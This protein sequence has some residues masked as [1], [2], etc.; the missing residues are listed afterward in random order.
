MT[1]YYFVLYF[2]LYGFLGWCTE[3]IYAAFKEKKFVNRG[4]LNGPLCP[5]YGVGVVV[6]VYF[7]DMFRSNLVLLYV[8]SVILV[9]TL[10]WVTGFIMEKLFRHKW[11]DYS[12]IPL[13]LNGYVC[14]PFSLIWG[15]GCVLIVDFI[16]PAV[17]SLMVHLPFK[18]GVVLMVLMGFGLIADIYVTVVGIAKIN[19]RLDKME[20]VAAELRELAENLGESLYKG[21]LDA[22]AKKEEVKQKF[23][24]SESVAKRIQELKKNYND[25]AAKRTYVSGRLMRAFP[26]MNSKK[27][28]EAWEDLRKRFKSS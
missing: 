17:H 26:K 23:D 6:V 4:F 13:N 20:K 15:V 18:L 5:I 25:L 2:F 21:V 14:L 1:V 19:Q 16:H 10:E 9:T 22:L 7:L 8:T 24:V 28:K 27:Y 3:V 12:N 11:W